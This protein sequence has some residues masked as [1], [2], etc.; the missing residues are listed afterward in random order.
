MNAGPSTPSSSAQANTTHAELKSKVVRV[1]MKGGFWDS[2]DV[3]ATVF[4]SD[5]IRNL[6]SI[7]PDGVDGS[8]HAFFINFPSAE[9]AQAQMEGWTVT[10]NRDW[11]YSLISDDELPIY[12]AYAESLADAVQRGV[13]VPATLGSPSG[14]DDEDAANDVQLAII[15]S[16]RPASPQRGPSPRSKRR[17]ISQDG[18]SVPTGRSSPPTFTAAD[19]W[20]AMEE[21]EEDL[22]LEWIPNQRT[23]K[24]SEKA[25]G[26]L[27]ERSG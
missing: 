19:V 11:E 6:V 23:S 26:K 13:Q 10:T 18:S 3:E 5:C 1:T 24:P 21:L 25:L 9:M 4:S 14:D 7:V 27:P 2:S 20:A 17:R 15:A 22:R 16:L 8:T 12:L